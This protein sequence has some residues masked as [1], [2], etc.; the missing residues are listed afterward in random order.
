[1][2]NLHDISEYIVFFIALFAARYSLTET[3]AYKYLQKYDAI[4]F[5]HDFYDVMHTQ[6]FDD[7][8]DS[9]AMYCR[10]KGGDIW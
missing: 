6:S 5:M 2:V 4:K 3:Q 9:I 1:M 10:R 7:M 8:I